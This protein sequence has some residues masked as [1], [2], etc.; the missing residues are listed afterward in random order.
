[1]KRIINI[2]FLIAGMVC[3]TCIMC[4]CSETGKSESDKAYSKSSDS[5]ESDAKRQA[6]IE[7]LTGL[8][9]KY[10][11]TIDKK[12]DWADKLVYES[13]KNLADEGAISPLP[14]DYKIFENVFEFEET[15]DGYGISFL[16]NDVETK[17]TADF[18]LDLTDGSKI[19]LCCEKHMQKE[20]GSRLRDLTVPYTDKDGAFSTAVYKHDEKLLSTPTL[21]P[22]GWSGMFAGIQ[23]DVPAEVFADTIDECRYLIAYGGCN[24]NV[25]EN[26]YAVSPVAEG[27]RDRTDVTTLVLII[28]AKEKRILHIENIGTDIPAAQTTDPTGNVLNEKAIEY[29]DNLLKTTKHIDTK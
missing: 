7:R 3:L 2:I 25:V 4:A 29:I 6:E 20:D 27:I 22:G 9:K 19:A 11:D 12:D 21:M 16:K 26:Y 5:G 17:L 23:K 18:K 24:S 1:M 13:L 8:E 10:T 15:V 14:D 28:D